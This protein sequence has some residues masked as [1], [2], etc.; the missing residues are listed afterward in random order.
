MVAVTY[1][2]L[3]IAIMTL[4]TVATRALPFLFLRGREHHPLLEYLGTYLPAAVMTILVLFAIRE[5]EI[6]ETPYGIPEA[7]SLVLTIGLHLWRRNALLSIG[8][9]TAAYM[10]M[11]QSQ[12]L[13]KLLV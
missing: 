12:V 9:G 6:L 10:Y 7:L 4:A 1:L 3:M 5:V 2:I 8:A 13:S 11:I